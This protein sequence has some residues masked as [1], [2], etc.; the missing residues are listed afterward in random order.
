[1]SVKLLED[2]GGALWH[3]NYRNLTLESADRVTNVS[4][5][6]QDTTYFAVFLQM[7]QR[8]KPAICFCYL[9]AEG[10]LLRTFLLKLIKTLNVGY[11]T[12]L[13]G[14]HWYAVML[15]FWCYY[16]IKLENSAPAFLDR[17]DTVT[18]SPWIGFD[19]FKMYQYSKIC[20]ML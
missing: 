6:I 5:R 13:T 19:L 10:R 2:D 11:I 14:C 4:S 15:S 8:S 12:W 17:H 20:I 3:I 9:N 1:M 18:C 16:L 7:I